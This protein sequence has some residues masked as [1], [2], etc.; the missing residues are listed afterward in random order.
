MELVIQM[1]EQNLITHVDDTTRGEYKIY[2]QLH[3][4]FIVSARSAIKDRYINIFSCVGGISE[5]DVMS[6][7]HIFDD[8]IHEIN[9]DVADLVSLD[10][11]LFFETDKRYNTL[12]L[13]W[14][15]NNVEDKVRAWCLLSSVFAHNSW[16]MRVNKRDVIDLL[17]EIAH[18]QVDPRD[19]KDYT[20]EQHSHFMSYAY[21]V[22]KNVKVSII[23]E[24]YKRNSVIAQY[25]LGEISDYRKV[26]EDFYPIKQQNIVDVDNFASFVDVISQ[27]DM[28]NTLF[29]HDILLSTE[30]LVNYFLCKK[31]AII[32]N[33]EAL[34]YMIKRFDEAGILPVDDIV[35][36]A[37]RFL[38]SKNEYEEFMS[39]IEVIDGHHDY[40]NGQ[41]DR[42]VDQVGKMREPYTHGG[43]KDVWS[44][45]VLIASL[46]KEAD[47]VD[48]FI[49]LGESVKEYCDNSVYALIN[50]DKGAWKGD[51]LSDERYIKAMLKSLATKIPFSLT[52]SMMGV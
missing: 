43:R 31:Y 27:S 50:R 36:F 5:L 17:K 23:S 9:L 4:E 33:K 2:T 25:F 47:T 16:Y 35:D 34:D 6:I 12:F 1:I 8:F 20:L 42:Y 24:N 52:A 15:K 49:A 22:G 44:F 30:N 28:D 7:V 13:E 10:N 45:Y 41:G 26:K 37:K 21:S 48:E 29:S 14:L 3:S 11:P 46:Y 32:L 18:N 39:A 40:M 38:L 19:F 51:F